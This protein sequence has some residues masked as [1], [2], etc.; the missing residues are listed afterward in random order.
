MTANAQK[1][2]DEALTLDAA[3]RADLAASLLDSLDEGEDAD[4]VQAWAQEI[5]RRLREVEAGTVKT[6]PWSE[7]RKRI[8]ALRND[9][10]RA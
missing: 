7:A 10:R 3:E 5:E 8:L 6:I 2:L 4:A 9:R 1:V